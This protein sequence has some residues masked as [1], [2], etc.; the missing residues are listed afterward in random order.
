MSSL[1]VI[2]ALH[3]IRR[4]SLP[5]SHIVILH[6]HKCGVRVC[7][8]IAVPTISHNLPLLL[9]LFLA[10]QIF[11]KL[12]VFLLLFTVPLPC[13]I[14]KHDLFPFLLQMLFELLQ[15]CDL[16]LFL[17][18]RLDFR[19]MLFCTSSPYKRI[20]ACSVFQFCSVNKADFMIRFSLC[21][22]YFDILAE[23]I[24]HRFCMPFP[25]PGKATVIRYCSPPSSHIKSTRYRQAS[26][27][28]LLL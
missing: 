14:H 17:Y 4:L 5:I 25:K 13:T 2:S 26:S 22:Q 23:Q 1:N 21:F 20:S 24:L 15:I 16:N 10:F 19:Q 6:S 28:S 12:L 11:S 18:R 8:G 9:V 7:F 3:M 27:R